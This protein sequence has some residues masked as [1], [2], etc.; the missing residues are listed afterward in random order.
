[1]RLIAAYFIFKLDQV[2]MVMK[3]F[4]S[5]VWV[6]GFKFRLISPVALVFIYSM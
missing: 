3:S 1:M 6:K 2:E 5:M 4:L